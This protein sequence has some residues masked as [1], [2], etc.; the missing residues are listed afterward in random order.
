M[1]NNCSLMQIKSKGF[2]TTV[3]LPVGE[4][5]FLDM[6]GDLPALAKMFNCSVDK[7]TD[8]MKLHF[9]ASV[10][11]KCAK[12]N[13]MADTIEFCLRIKRI[14]PDV[15]SISDEDGAFRFLAT[16]EAA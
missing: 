7:I 5:Q 4:I 11:I 6:P 2:E 15:Y 1:I 12:A 10:A 14:I 8:Q 3:N 13:D 16:P 9:F